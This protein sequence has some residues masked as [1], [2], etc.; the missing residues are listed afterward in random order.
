MDN[1]KRGALQP[2]K[3]IF[4][5]PEKRQTGILEFQ[6]L[7][8]NPGWILLVLILE[9]NIKLLERQILE[10]TGLSKEEEFELKTKR[11]LFIFLKDLPDIE[12]NELS[13]SEDS[14]PNPDPFT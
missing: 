4:D 14:N 9:E 7:K 1:K 13:T 8:A 2:P 6:G 5:T 11:K 12:I 3:D 10:T